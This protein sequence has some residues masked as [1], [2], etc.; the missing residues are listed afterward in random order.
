[1]LKI[2][3]KIGGKEKTVDTVD[4]VEAANAVN[5]TEGAREHQL[6]SV[7]SELIDQAMEFQQLMVFYDAGI[8]QIRTKLDILN[9]EFQCSNDRNPIENIKSRIKAPDSIRKKLE[10]L[11]MPITLSNMTNY[12]YDI[13][14]IRVICP[15]ISDVYQVADM[16]LKQDDVELVKIKDYIKNPKENGYRSLHV[17]VKVDV[18]FSDQKRKVPVELQFRTIAMNFW[19]SL[20]HQLRYKKDYEFTHEMQ[21]ELKECAELIANTDKR[22]QRLANQLPSFN[23]ISDFDDMLDIW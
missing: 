1:M 11:G 2:F 17:I 23:A 3:S 21:A 12:L 10:K 15:F 14:G 4:T 16:L 18:F 6:V 7:S 5:G 20:E 9:K 13:A 8:Q 22:M 19:A